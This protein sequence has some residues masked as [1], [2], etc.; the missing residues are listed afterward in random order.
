MIANIG[1]QWNPS[2]ENPTY[3]YTLAL[4]HAFAYSMLTAKI[5]N[6]SGESAD[7]PWDLLVK[8]YA[9]LPTDYTFENAPQ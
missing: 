5:R 7:S 1:G 4:D 9:N 6:E 8:H 3:N 2:S